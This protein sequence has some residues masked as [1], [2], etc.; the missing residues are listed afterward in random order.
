[1]AKGESAGQAS[2]LSTNQSDIG[3][4]ANINLD[5]TSPGVMIV[6]L[7]PTNQVVT[8]ATASTASMYA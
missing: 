3:K 8:G 7:S 6:N 4:D 2:L 1:M 5:D